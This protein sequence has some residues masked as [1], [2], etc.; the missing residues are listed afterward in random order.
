MSRLAKQKGIDLAIQA[1]NELKLPL[2]IVGVGSQEQY[3]RSIAGDTVT[4]KGYVPDQEMAEIYAHAKA[5]IYCSIEEDFG[6]VPVEAMAHGLPVIGY[7][8]GGTAET[9]INNKTGVLFDHFSVPALKKAIQLFNKQ[10]IP[11]ANCIH[12]AKK[13]ADAKFKQKIKQVVRKYYAQ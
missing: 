11:A 10:K 9:V 5:L 8:S 6:L 4:F 12:H 1:C 7:R 13:Y 3:L 2:V